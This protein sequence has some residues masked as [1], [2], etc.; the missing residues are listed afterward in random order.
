MSVVDRIEA[1]IKEKG[2]NFKRVERE[3]GLGNGT[4]KRW[5]T[6]SPRLD[7]L[8]KVSEYL[9]VSLDY[10]VYGTGDSNRTETV[11]D[12]V[13]LT[14]SEADLVAMYRLIEEADRKTIFDLTKLKYEQ[15]T[16]EKVSIYST[17]TDVKERQKSGSDR[18]DKSATGTA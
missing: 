13:P 12:G 2:L 11:C 4:I 9:K 7:K 15:S 17:Y 8:A 1:V 5:E 16:G 10:L 18:D 14:E 3:C 6:Q